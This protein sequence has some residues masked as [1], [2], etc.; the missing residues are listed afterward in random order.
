[1]PTIARFYGIEIR[2]YYKDHAPP[3]F[4]AIYGEYEAQVQIS[5][6]ALLD[7]E[8]PRRASAL[9]LDW[10]RQ[11]EAELLENWQRARA[12]LPLLPIAP[13]E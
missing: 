7:G 11:H 1:M 12:Q 10:A 8:L 9:A 13:L 6:V 2:M 5:A 4:H 3:H